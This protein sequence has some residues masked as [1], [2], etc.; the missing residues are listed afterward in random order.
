MVKQ[1]ELQPAPGSKFKHKRVGRG[2]GSGHGT[3]SGR[4]QKGQKARAG[5]GVRP[6]FEGG[7]LPLIKRLPSKRGFK[8]IFKKEFSLV[9]IGSLNKFE[10]GTEVT[11]QKMVEAGLIKSLKNPVKVLGD[12][13]LEHALVVK[14][15]AFSASSRAMLEELGGKAEVIA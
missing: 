8:N 13:K 5:G 14:A 3:Y 1:N 11:P 2:D 6:G 4:G 7:Q 15:H 10:S 12:G 9:D